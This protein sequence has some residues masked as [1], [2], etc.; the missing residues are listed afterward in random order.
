MRSSS[1]A[2]TCFTAVGF[3]VLLPLAAT[4]CRRDAARPPAVGTLERDRIELIAEA[5]EPIREIPVREGDNVSRGDLV[6]SLDDERARL[7]VQEARAA[8]DRADAVLAEMLRG[9][10]PEEIAE[11]EANVAEVEAEIVEAALELQRMEALVADDVESQRNLDIARRR[12]DA[13][14]ARRHAVRAVLERLLNGV[15]VE[16]LDQARAALAEVEARFDATRVDLERLRI[17]ALRDGRIDALP[18]KVGDTPP[19]GAVVAVVL[20]GGAPYARVHVVAATRP[21]VNPGDDAVVHVEGLERSFAGR[22]RWVSA[23]AAFTPFYA[24]TERDRGR[25]TYLAEVDLLESEAGEL[26]TGLPVEVTFAGGP[27][28]DGARDD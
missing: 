4:G 16:E 14:G 3:A 13:A 1:T 19:P 15:T 21:S 2:W 7:R 6:V 10:R 26:P 11:A 8:R 22:V 28:R 18:F 23:E 24:L 5:Q 17:V 20:A 27:E 9:T 25:L 12:Y